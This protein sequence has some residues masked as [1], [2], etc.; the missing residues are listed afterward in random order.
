VL[1]DFFERVTVLERDAYPA[2]AADRPGVPHGRSFHVLQPR[3][4][5]ELEDLFPGFER[6]MRDRGSAQIEMGVNYAV[7]T[8]VGW[9]PPRPKFSRTT[10]QASRAL[11]D[12]TI[13]GLCAK[14]PNVILQQHTLVT[15]LIIEPG[16]FPRCVGVTTSDGNR[17]EADLI[18][19]AAG[20]ST[21][22]PDWLAAA[23]VEPPDETV[24]DAFVGYCGVWLRMRQGVEWPKNWWWTGG[25]AIGPLPPS[26]GRAIILTRHEND[27]WLLSLSGRD[28][29]YPP[30]DFEAIRA[31]LSV[32]RSP[33]IAKMVDLME[34]V[35]LARGYRPAGNRWRHYERWRKPLTGFISIGDAFC[36]YN[37]TNGLGM[38]AAAVS[39]QV[40][41]DLLKR[42]NT[43]GLEFTKRFHR[44]QAKVQ[45]GLWE[46][47]IGND[48]RFPNTEGQRATKTRLITWY[49]DLAMRSTRDPVVQ[50]R[51]REV[52]GMMMPVSA[53]W[54][55]SIAWRVIRSEINRARYRRRSK[56]RAIP[57]MPPPMPEAST[58]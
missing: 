14:I 21:K 18:A 43:D 57:P 12:A 53:L 56:P 19:D 31:M 45:R 25:A 1:S 9:I 16:N 46:I 39:A 26:D 22:A 40:L 3:G 23:G 29:D 2:D 33:V 47:A 48:F 24:V 42:K 58:R 55:P 30:Q 44:E 52:A 20:V 50:E 13:R 36:A 51:V 41:R 6:L 54:A 4:L 38:S 15:G 11:I 34:P 17:V 32:A 49:R 5:C 10:L 8:P 35:S 7:L 27:R 28:R 37:P